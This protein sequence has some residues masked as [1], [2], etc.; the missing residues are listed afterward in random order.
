VNYAP[1][2][3]YRGFWRRFDQGKNFPEAAGEKIRGHFE[4]AALPDDQLTVRGALSSVSTEGA[5]AN[6]IAWTPVSDF[7]AVRRQAGILYG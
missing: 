1:S 3:V 4:F 7:D 5:I 6:M 2:Q